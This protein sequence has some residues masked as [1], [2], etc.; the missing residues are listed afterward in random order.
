MLHVE[1]GS[2]H[3]QYFVALVLQQVVSTC[4]VTDMKR[5]NFNIF[6]KQLLQFVCCL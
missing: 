1:A 4:D 3:L 6:A 5:T 2:C